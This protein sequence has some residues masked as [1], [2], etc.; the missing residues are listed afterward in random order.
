MTPSAQISFEIDVCFHTLLPITVL[1]THADNIECS[2][3]VFPVNKKNFSFLITVV[4]FIIL[5]R[6]P[7]NLVGLIWKTAIFG[8]WLFSRQV[9]LKIILAV[10]RNHLRIIFKC[11]YTLSLMYNWNSL[12]YQHGVYTYIHTY[13]YIYIYTYTYIYIYIYTYSHTTILYTR[14][15]IYIYIYIYVSVC[16]CV[17]IYTYNWI[18]KYCTYIL[19]NGCSIREFP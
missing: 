5:I 17:C 8:K 4:F 15:Y 3:V 9:F 10:Q 12:L 6:T 19:W 2:F 11:L 14:L 1:T 7:L 18:R 13:T 16:V